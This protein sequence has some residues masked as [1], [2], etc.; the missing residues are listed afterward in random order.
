MVLLSVACLILVIHTLSALDVIFGVR[1]MTH[2]SEISPVDQSEGPL[3]SVI[4][5]ACNEEEQIEAVI[6]ALGLQDYKNVEII[7]VNDRSTD[8]TGVI[9]DRLKIA[10]SNLSVIHISDLP[11]GWLGKT[12]AMHVSAGVARGTYLLFTDGDVVLAPSTISRAVYRMQSK[13]LDHLTLLFENISKSWLLNSMVLDAG[14]NLLQFLRV[15]RAKDTRSPHF[16]GVGAFNMVSRKMY[17]AVG[18]HTSFK[19]HPIDDIM[20]GKVIKRSGGAQECLLGHGMVTLPWYASVGDMVNGLMKNCLGVINYRFSLLPLLLLTMIV[21]NIMPFWA[22]ILC[23]GVTRIIFALILIVKLLPSLMGARL[24]G[25]SVWCSLGTLISPYILLY[26]LQRAAYRIW[27]DGGIY[28]RSTFYP[29]SYL[30]NNESIL[31]LGR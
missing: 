18:G 5:P 3:V 6:S 23:D 15:W 24:L 26:T 21:L 13:Q 31:F 14:I 9:L 25:L 8:G 20:L 30:K 22:F 10:M 16:V 1:S 19:T 7:A 11:S 28:W 12:H 4:I 17:T 2:I 27:R 29:L